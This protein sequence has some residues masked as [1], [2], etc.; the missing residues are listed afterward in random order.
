VAVRAVEAGP[1]PLDD[2]GGEDEREVAAGW[3][4]GDRGDIPPRVVA[5]PFDLLHRSTL[6]LSPS[7]EHAI[8]DIID[9]VFLPLASR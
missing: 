5:L 1:D 6:L 7:D 8:T 2:R 4:E 9:Q 3:R